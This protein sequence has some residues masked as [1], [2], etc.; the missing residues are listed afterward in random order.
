MAS[1]LV[2]WVLGVSWDQIEGDYLA[3]NLVAPLE[4]SIDYAARMAALNSAVRFL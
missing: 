1:M 4:D 2:E 3:T